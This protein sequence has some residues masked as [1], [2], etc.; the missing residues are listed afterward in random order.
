VTSGAPEIRG[1][2]A[3]GLEPVRDVLD[4]LVVDGVEDAVQVHAIS[5]GEPVVDL[6]AGLRPDALVNTYS[7][8]KPFAAFCALV[9]V[10]RGVLDLDEPIANRWRAYG[11]HGKERTTLRQWL[12]HQAGVPQLRQP[13]TSDVLTD[14]DAMCARIADEPPQWEPGTAHGEHA[15]TYGHVIA[16]LIR[17]TDG[18]D[19]GTFW[20]EEIATPWEL[21]FHIGVPPDELHRVHDLTVSTSDV[22]NSTAWRTAQIPAVNGHGTARAIARYYAKLLEEPNGLVGADTVKTMLTPHAVGPDRITGHAITWGLGV[23]LEPQGDF[24]MGGIGGSLGFANREDGLAYAYVTA[25][26]GDH[27]R[28]VKVEDKLRA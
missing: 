15:L 7:V 20:H 14:H 11:R 9:L 5:H 6:H 1:F 4:A 8:V 18:R 21:D 10:D 25:R 13:P 22:V 2:V 28:T 17:R 19:L 12:A 27:E 3:P 16:E 23:W 26:M 24:G